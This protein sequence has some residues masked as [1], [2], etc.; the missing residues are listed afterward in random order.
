[1]N[2]ANRSGKTF[3]QAVAILS[4]VIKGES[5][6]FVK[7]EGSFLIKA[8][9]VKMTNTRPPEPTQIWYDEGE[10]L[11]RNVDHFLEI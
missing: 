7:P 4:A 2:R 11:W 6:L 10:K 1:M 8:E 5:V 3:S 9:K